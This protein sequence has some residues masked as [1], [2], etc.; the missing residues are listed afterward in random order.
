MKKFLVVLMSIAIIG[1]GFYYYMKEYNSVGSLPTF[2]SKIY[3]PQTKYVIK[4][5]GR[6]V[7]GADTKEEAIEKA[8]GI[9]RSIVINTLNNEWVYS[10]LRPFMI[11]TDN[12]IHDFDDLTEAIVY[13]KK[14]DYETIHYRDDSHCIWKKNAQPVMQQPL[15]VPLVLQMPELPRGCEVTSLA[16]VLK[17][18]GIDANKMDLAKQ[19]KKDTTPYSKDA[20]GKIVYG[21]PYDGFVGDMYN[22][23]KAGYGVYHGPIADLA[24]TYAGDDVQDLTGLDFEDVISILSNGYPVWVITNATYKTL[25]D[26]QFEIWHTPTGIVKTTYKLHSVVMTGVTESK[27]YVNDPAV[28]SKNNV[29]DRK[30]FQKAWEQMGNQAIVIIK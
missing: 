10:E 14:N 27:I 23:K 9:P 8:K 24:Q 3:T 17:Y 15:D 21:N 16:M 30:S 25:D 19:V 20:E 13:A 11:I 2:I 7:N 6:V 22:I 4:K 1:G 26:S 28:N 5:A 29:L 12:A 18:N